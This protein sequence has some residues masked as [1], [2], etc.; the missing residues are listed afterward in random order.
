MT[1]LTVNISTDIS[2]KTDFEDENGIAKAD[3]VFVHI[4]V[5]N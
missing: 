2:N 3:R 1:K 5:K 4:V